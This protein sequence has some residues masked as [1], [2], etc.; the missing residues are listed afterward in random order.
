MVTALQEPSKRQTQYVVLSGI[1][2]QTYHAILT[3][4]GEHRSARLAYSQGV[5]EI[6]MPSELHEFISRILEA[7]VRTLAEEF[8]Q[9]LRGYGS[10]TLD[11]EELV[12]GVEPDCCFYIQNVERILGRRQLDLNTDP[13]PDLAI[14]VDITSS[15]RRR[16]GIYL[17]LEIPEVWRYTERNGVTIY[18]LEG[19]RY[20]EC[21]FS[22]TFP[23]ISGVVL[24]QFLQLTV[25]EDDISVVRAVRQWVQ[26]QSR[27]S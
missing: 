11:R 3:D 22:P 21:E 1:T 18:Q 5:L 26:S 13:P 20:V 2:W 12:Q 16:F 27:Q 6:I 17:Q 23:I 14:E 9:R 19:D 4:M 8:N 25:S 10:N 15:S 7:I 24:S